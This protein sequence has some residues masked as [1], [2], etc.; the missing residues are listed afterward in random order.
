MESAV[1]EGAYALLDYFTE[2]GHQV[3]IVPHNGSKNNMYNY[4]WHVVVNVKSY[5]TGLTLLDKY[6]TY[7]AII[8]YLNQ[9]PH[10]HWSWSYHN[11]ERIK[12]QEYL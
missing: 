7:N 9:S 8:N 5:S 11:N 3:L 6:S 1:D 12:P 2:L 10:T 4:H